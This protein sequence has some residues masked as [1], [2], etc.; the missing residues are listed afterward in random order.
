MNTKWEERTLDELCSVITDGAHRSP[1][2]TVEG[3]PMASVK[4]M[5][6]FGIDYDSARTISKE[7]YETLKKSGCCPQI[8][9]V[10]IAK[11]GSVLESVCV[12]N[13]QRE[14]CLL[15]SIAIFRPGENLDPYFLK[16]FFESPKTK[17]IAKN[18]YI[19]GSAIP[20]IVL[21]DFKQFPI[22]LPNI[23]QQKVI[24][25]FLRKIDEKIEVNQKENNTLEEMAKA[26][27]K[28]WLIDL[29]L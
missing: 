6:S 26:I 11:D 24:A 12:H 20:R 8:G 3:I 7:E 19:T 4:D 16:Y 25:N 23:D 1:K 9:D 28:S 18:G 17:Y 10:L 27:F 15:S 14:I 21:K 29:I 2:S 13:D 5:T 22:K